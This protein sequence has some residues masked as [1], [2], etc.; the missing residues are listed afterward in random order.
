ML[1]EMIHLTRIRMS[2]LR[3]MWMRVY[4]HLIAFQ[5]GRRPRKYSCFS[6]LVS[7]VGE[8]YFGQMTNQLRAKGGQ[9]F[10]AI[11]ERLVLKS[12]SDIAFAE[13]AE[14]MLKDKE[15][16][17]KRKE[18][19]QI[20][21]LWSRAQHD[22]IRSKIAIS[23]SEADILAREQTRNGNGMEKGSNTTPQFHLKRM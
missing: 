16:R 1:L 17:K 2:S 19:E 13:G 3:L 22:V 11:G 10:K 5:H 23:D 12:N 20:E 6:S 9:A 7:K 21:A 8:N 15:L 4:F 14:K 18:I